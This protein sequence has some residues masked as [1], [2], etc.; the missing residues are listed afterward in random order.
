MTVMGA[1]GVALRRFGL[2]GEV[3]IFSARGFGIGGGKGRERS[4]SLADSKP[5]ALTALSLL[6]LILRR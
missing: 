2:V 6:E 4:P 5:S 1:S 3:V